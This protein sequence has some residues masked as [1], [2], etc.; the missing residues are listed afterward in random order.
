[1]EFEKKLNNPGK[2]EFCEK[3]SQNHQL[4]DSEN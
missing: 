4:S 2:M 1:M 3:I